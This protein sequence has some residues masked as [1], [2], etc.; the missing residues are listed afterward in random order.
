VRWDDTSIPDVTLEAWPNAMAVQVCD[1]PPIECTNVP[2][3]LDDYKM[4]VVPAYHDDATGFG[5]RVNQPSAD[6]ITAPTP[7]AAAGIANAPYADRQDLF[8]CFHIPGATHYRVVASF[9]GGTPQPILAGDFT[10]TTS[11]G[12]DVQT[13]LADGCY[14][15]RA[16]L[17]SS[18]EHF[19]LGWMP[20]QVGIYEIKLEVGTLSGSV[21]TPTASSAPH[22]FEADATTPVGTF[23]QIRWWHTV[24]GPGTAATL[25]AICPVIERD[26]TKEV[27]VE[28]T[29]SASALHLRN[30]VLGMYGCGAGDPTP[31]AL[32]DRSW[33][34]QLPSET[35]TGVKVAQFKI[36]SL[37]QA[38]CYTVYI[39]AVSRAYNPA[40]PS[41]PLSANW[42]YP[43][44]RRWTWPSRAISVVDS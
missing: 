24:D 20:A 35:S 25:P 26:A 5:I 10:V 41:M 34:W 33:Y 13:Q 18:S 12:P 22:T 40:I 19:I 4:P 21:F 27:T 36:P 3:I 7:G 37:L 15:I 38:G 31:P 39:N 8:G 32:G 17:V 11:T 9:M 42:Y 14:L 30:A 28:V 2:A 43:E 16:D 29:W 1:G 44:D 6:G 23:N